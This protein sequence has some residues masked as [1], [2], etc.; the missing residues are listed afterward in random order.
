MIMGAATRLFRNGARRV[1]LTAERTER[2]KE[3]TMPDYTPVSTA[4]LLALAGL[5]LKRAR[6]SLPCTSREQAL[7]IVQGIRPAPPRKAKLHIKP[8]YALCCVCFKPLI[9]GTLVDSL[10]R[11]HAT[12]ELRRELL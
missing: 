4:A 9:T 6:L 7:R 3:T 11:Q 1:A 12:C 8:I 2:G 10:G 5:I